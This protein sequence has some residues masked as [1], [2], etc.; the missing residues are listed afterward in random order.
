MA[1]YIDGF[2]LWGVY[3]FLHPQTFDLCQ[4]RDPLVLC[5]TEEE[6][7]KAKVEYEKNPDEK[8]DYVYV[9]E[10]RQLDL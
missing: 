6:A 10:D 5:F 4:S 2:T 3:S 1:N 7:E 8:Y 9:E